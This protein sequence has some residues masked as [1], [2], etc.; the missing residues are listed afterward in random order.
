MTRAKTKEKKGLN[1]WDQGNSQVLSG[2]VKAGH[3]D[4]HHRS[5]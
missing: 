1:S 2:V 3:G 4:A 5:A